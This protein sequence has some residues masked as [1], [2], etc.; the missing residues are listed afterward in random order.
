[1]EAPLVRIDAFQGSVDEA[2][3]CRR[4]PRLRVEHLALWAAEGALSRLIPASAPVK[5]ARLTPYGLHL[6]VELSLTTVR[7]DV[8]VFATPHGRLGLE[9]TSVATDLLGVPTSLVAAAIREFLPA[10]PWLH[11]GPGARWEADLVSLAA[12]FGIDLAPVAA[13]RS[14]PGGIELEFSRT[15]A[16]TAPPPTRPRGFA[17]MPAPEPPVQIGRLALCP[18]CEA[19]LMDQPPACPSCGLAVQYDARGRAAPASN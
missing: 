10:Q 11:Q 7:A 3:L 16:G 18:S 5:T 9:I 2:A 6:Q 17:D 12:P 4:E 19:I 8:R 1:L 15:S 13:V 14:G